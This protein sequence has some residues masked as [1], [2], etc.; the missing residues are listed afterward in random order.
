MKEIKNN[1]L[2]LNT[3]SNNE[4]ETNAKTDEKNI[5]GSDFKEGNTTGLNEYLKDDE[6]VEETL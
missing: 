3:Q 2:D 1:D 6:V 5:E 4:R